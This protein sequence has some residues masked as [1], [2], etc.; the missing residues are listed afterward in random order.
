MLQT[1]SAENS[2]KFYRP[3]AAKVKYPYISDYSLP[4]RKTT[5]KTNLK[6]I[7]WTK[8]KIPFETLKYTS[9]PSVFTPKFCV[10]NNEAF[11]ISLSVILLASLFKCT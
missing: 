3:F 1:V 5:N 10:I 2:S 11:F 9:F 8:E 4:V 6:N 7:Y